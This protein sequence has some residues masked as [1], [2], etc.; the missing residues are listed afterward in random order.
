MKRGGERG[1]K[2]KPRDEERGNDDCERVRERKG[3]LNRDKEII[4]HRLKYN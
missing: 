4:H 3:E 1:E 2:I